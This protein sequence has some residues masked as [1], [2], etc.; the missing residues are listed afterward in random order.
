MTKKGWVS[1]DARLGWERKSRFKSDGWENKLGSVTY[2]SFC[3][4]F[5]KTYIQNLLHNAWVFLKK[6]YAKKYLLYLKKYFI[7]VDY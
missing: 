3:I 7:C 2:K 6:I 5:W 1:D 4:N